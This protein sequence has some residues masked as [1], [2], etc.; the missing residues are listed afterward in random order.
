MILVEDGCYSNIWYEMLWHM[1]WNYGAEKDELEKIML[2]YVRWIF[3]LDF[4][5]PRYV[6]MK[7]LIIDKFKVG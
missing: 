3:K 7:K 5:I 1:K 6:I 4:C 2:D